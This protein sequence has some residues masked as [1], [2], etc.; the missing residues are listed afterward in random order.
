MTRTYKEWAEIYEKA[1]NAG[2]ESVGDYL[3]DL[4]RGYC[5][6]DLIE[7]VEVKDSE[8]DLEIN[9]NLEKF[10]LISEE[11]QEAKWKYLSSAVR[12]MEKQYEESHPDS[13]RLLIMDSVQMLRES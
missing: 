4:S 10:R 11:I 12:A 7:T 3:T 1:M 9:K 6:T 13:Q 5:P 8:K 2:Y